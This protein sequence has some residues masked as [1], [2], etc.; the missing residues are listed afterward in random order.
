MSSA[1][2]KA[3]AV[4]LWWF[5]S[6]R[7]HPGDEVLPEERLAAPR[8]SGFDSRRLHHALVVSTA[9]HAPFVRPK[10]GFDSCRGLSRG[11]SSAGRAPER[12]SGEARSTRAVRFTGPWCNREHG[13]LQPRESGFESWRACFS[14]GVNRSP[15]EPCSF[16]AAKPTPSGICPPWAGIRAGESARR[17]PPA[18]EQRGVEM[19]QHPHLARATAPTKRP[20][21]PAKVIVL[22]ARRKARLEATRPE[23]QPPP[24]R[25]AA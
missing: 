6:T 14:T 10:C 9:Q 16:A 1:A 7:P 15:H 12:H 24:L 22:D 25:P 23:R 11:R 5:D 8:R 18:N 19:H 21:R 13:E 17:I 4:A 20:Q 2:C 3:V